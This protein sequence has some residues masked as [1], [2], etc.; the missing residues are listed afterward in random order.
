MNTIEKLKKIH[1]LSLSMIVK[2]FYWNF[3]LNLIDVV[4]VVSYALALHLRLVTRLA[5][6]LRYY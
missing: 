5:M 4:V 1:G 6:Q 2:M 3:H